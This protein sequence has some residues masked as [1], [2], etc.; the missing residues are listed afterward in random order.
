MN[1]HALKSLYLSGATKVDDFQL[2]HLS[3]LVNLEFLLL[4]FTAV[5]AKAL[6]GLYH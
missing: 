1:L 6:L 5:T 2:V 4:A 3:K